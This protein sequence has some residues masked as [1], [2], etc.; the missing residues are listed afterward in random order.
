MDNISIKLMK[1]LDDDCLILVLK[2]N[3]WL[4]YR[5]LYVDSG[6]GF[7]RITHKEIMSQW[8]FIDNKMMTKIYTLMY[9]R[10]IDGLIRR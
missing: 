5:I 4:Y 10:N 7:L 2:K 3:T 9:Q 6:T 8:K 1:S